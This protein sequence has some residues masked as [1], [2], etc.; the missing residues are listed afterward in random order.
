MNIDLT[1]IDINSDK[2]IDIDSE[3][4]IDHDWFNNTS[5]RDLVNVKFVGK[6]VRTGDSN[7]HL[8]GNLE[9]CMV[10]PDDITL[11]DVNYPFN[12]AIDED[13]N[14]DENDDKNIK[15]I[16]NKLD[17]TDFLWQ[18]IL[19]EIPLKVKNPGNDNINLKG[20]GWRLVTED[21]ILKGN[22]SPL[23]ELSKLFDSRKE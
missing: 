21:E 6:I 17:I 23:N 19:V 15:I 8:F 1:S 11:E 7:Y 13:I 10:L 3:V 16:Q 18:N 12:I 4:D 14:N 22:N 2:F 20:N 5:I 9:G